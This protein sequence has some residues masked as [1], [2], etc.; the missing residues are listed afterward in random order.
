MSYSY[1]FTHNLRDEATFKSNL[2]LYAGEMLTN[3]NTYEIT[4]KTNRN[5]FTEL[6]SYLHLKNWNNQP[7]NMCREITLGNEEEVLL[8]LLKKFQYPNFCAR[9][10]LNAKDLNIKLIPMRTILKLL[11]I[12]HLDTP[13]T[14]PYLTREEISLFIFSNPNVYLNGPDVDHIGFWNHILEFRNTNVTPS[15]LDTS[16]S[17]KDRELTDMFKLMSYTGLIL[18]TKNDGKDCLVLDYLN[19]TQDLKQATLDIIS[20]T[21]Y[22]DI[23]NNDTATKESYYSY[24]DI[25]NSYDDSLQPNMDLSH[26]LQW[27]NSHPTQRYSDKLIANFH[28]NLNCLPD[29]HFI[30]ISGVSGTGKTN[31]IKQYANAIYNIEDDKNPY[32][33]LISVR[34]DWEDEKP[35]FGYY[36]AL[37]KKYEVPTFLKTLILASQNPDKK[38]FICLDEMNLAHV[39][40]YFSDY[41]S[42]V[43]ANEPINLNNFYIKELYIPSNVFIIGTINEDETTE[44]ISDKVLDRAFKIEMNE[45]NVDD[46]IENYCT[47]KSKDP[48]IKEDLNFLS[49]VNLELSR[50][51]MNF[52]YRFIK[53]II[54]KLNYN[55]QELNSFFPTEELVDNTLLEKVIPKLKIEIMDKETLEQLIS[56]I[57]EAKYPNTCKKLKDMREIIES[58]TGVWG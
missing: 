19:L 37:E 17:I 10:G 35:L 40:Y 15:F 27:F 22:F 3:Y 43:E 24:M 29:K 48:Q 28:I 52:G 44:R 8:N 23:T 18:Y 47:F 53:E 12:K 9:N 25:P 4:N 7:T 6:L 56:H 46:Y 1:P 55:Y 36:N 54:E 26:I 14:Q 41:L 50:V 39:E 20:E 13:N 31:L 30:I 32:F 5:K 57:P 38:Y 16:I 34:P 11:Y 2:R 51:N 21:S 58:N 42:A 49:A 45:V 33:Q